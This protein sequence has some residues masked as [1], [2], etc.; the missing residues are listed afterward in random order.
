MIS[1]N[2]KDWVQGWEMVAFYPESGS[3]FAGVYVFKRQK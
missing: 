3:A 1:V 2:Q